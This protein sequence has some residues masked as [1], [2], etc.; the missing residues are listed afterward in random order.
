MLIA[1]P[2]NRLLKYQ[3]AAQITLISLL[4]LFLGHLF[5]VTNIGLVFFGLLIISYLIY[6]STLGKNDIFSFVMVMYFCNS[7]PYYFNGGAFNLVIFICIIFFL[8]MFKRFPRESKV[9]DPMFKWLVGLFVMS[10]FL[11]WVFNYTGSMKHLFYS[12]WSF[13]GIIFILLISSSLIMTR[14]RIK[15]FLQVNFILII[16][17]TISS[18]NTYIKFIPFETPM[19][20]SYQGGGTSS[21]YFE[22]GGIIGLSPLYGEHSMILLMLFVTYLLFLKNDF[23]KKSTLLIGIFLA[24]INIFMSISRSVLMLSLMGIAL[25]IIFQYKLTSIKMSRM[26]TQIFIIIIIG[27]SVLLFINRSGLSYVFD[28]VEN[29]EESNKSAGGISIERIVNGNAIN[30]DAAFEEGYKRYASKDSWIVGYGWGFGEEL[31][32]AF[33]V[34]TSIERGTAHSQI[35]ASL[36]VFGWIGFIGYWGLLFRII[37]RSYKTAGNKKTDYSVRLQA[38]FF[39][40]AI[41]LLTLNEIKVD[42]LS[43]P[44]YFTLTFIWMGLALSA[45]NSQPKHISTRQSL[46]LNSTNI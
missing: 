16:Y 43:F 27:G 24:S 12:V 34:D 38:Y 23:I 15:V 14:A 19:M 41:S 22:A 26:I 29:L 2:T 45:I 5:L 21:G 35:F 4:S 3:S 40:I 33:F 9:K 17:S 30:R 10:S 36:F 6:E 7:F 39:M 31:R 25:I 44:S 20:P 32:D 42:S 46:A 11:G 1:N 28:R 18:L 13:G 37:F 8:I